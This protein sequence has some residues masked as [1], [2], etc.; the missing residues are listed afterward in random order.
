MLNFEN[1]GHLARRTTAYNVSEIGDE[2]TTV[3]RV[4]GD[5]GE[6]IPVNL[7]AAEIAVV[8]HLRDC[9]RQFLSF[10]GEAFDEGPR[11]SGQLDVLGASG[12]WTVDLAGA[13]DCVILTIPR[14]RPGD[15]KVVG[16]DRPLASFHEHDVIM[17]GLA[18]SLIFSTSHTQTANILF[19]QSIISAIML[20]L[21]EIIAGPTDVAERSDKIA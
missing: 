6:A 20:H 18:R 9:P 2:K 15:Y 17:L 21:S 4:Q 7:E 12:S 10:D 14:E 19:T 16:P 8:V 13:I 1:F 5:R 3:K 11:L